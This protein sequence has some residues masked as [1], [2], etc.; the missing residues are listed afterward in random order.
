MPYAVEMFLNPKC[1]A[2]IRAVWH[3]LADAGIESSLLDI[4]SRP[5]LT[6]AIFDEVRLEEME[7]GL[8]SFARDI[9]PFPVAFWSL[10]AFGAPRGVVVLAAGVTQRLLEIHAAFHRRFG[11]LGTRPWGVYLPGRWVPHATLAT[12][13][14]ERALPK[15]FALAAEVPL[16]I[17]GTVRE[18][19]VVK[20]PPAEYL[21]TCELTGS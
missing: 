6:L 13:V 19:A 15:A 18:L 21:Y 20:F 2:A 17:E 14:P 3:R 10:G 5:H 1:E 4:R 8:E 12:G 9:P 16:P 7:P 11:G